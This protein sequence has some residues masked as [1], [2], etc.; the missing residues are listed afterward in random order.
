MDSARFDGMTRALVGRSRRRVLGGLAGALGLA[1]IAVPGGE[2]RK[3]KRKTKPTVV[4]NQYGCVDVGKACGGNNANCCSGICQTIPGKKRKHG[5][6]RKATSVCVA[7]N[8][9]TCPTG[10]NYSCAGDNTPLCAGLKGSC[11]QT[12]GRGAFCASITFP[13]DPFCSPCKKDIDCQGQFGPG[14]ACIDCYEPCA[15]TQ[16]RACSPP[17][18]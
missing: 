1:S 11:L 12:T 4:F 6:K 2:A 7:H 16:G 9:D 17:A 15:A 8:V 3:K 14:A 10:D 5:K 18:A 13:S